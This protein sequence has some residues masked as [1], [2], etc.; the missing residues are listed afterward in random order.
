M[1]GLT[2]SSLFRNLY[3]CFKVNTL[4]EYILNVSPY[5]SPECQIKHI[6]FIFIWP[7][8]YIKMYTKKFIKMLSFIVAE[9]ARN[10]PT[11]V[12]W[13]IIM[14]LSKSVLKY[15]LKFYSERMKWMYFAP[16]PSV[17]YN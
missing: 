4:K 17:N 5:L 8:I 12:L 7:Q 15:K 3:S 10:I 2:V 13:T 6:S 11:N 14:C 16:I 9:T 1:H